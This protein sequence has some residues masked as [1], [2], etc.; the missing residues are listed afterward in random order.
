MQALSTAVPG[1]WYTIKWMFG[2]P[3]VLEKLKEFK[4]KEGSEIHVIQNDASG[5]MIIASDQ[6]RFAIS[7]DAAA[8]NSS[9]TKK[10]KNRP[11]NHRKSRIDFLYIR[12]MEEPVCSI[13]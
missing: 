1:K 3:E 11:Y 2:V 6:K 10:W 5:M 8:E 7:Q 12:I 9:I 4:I 13:L